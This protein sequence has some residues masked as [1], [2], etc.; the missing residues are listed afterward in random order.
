MNRSLRHSTG[1]AALALTAAFGLAA[2]SDD[3]D[4]SDTASD[5]TSSA[6]TSEAPMDDA[7]T[8][9][10]GAGCSSIPTDGAGSFS[11]MAS[12]PVAT[13]AS[14]NPLLKTLVTAVGA[15]NLVDT[16]NSSEGITVFAPTDDAFAQIPKAD[17]DA[18][19]A[20][21]DALTQVL[22]YHVVPGQ[23]PP[24]ELA[25]TH[26][27]LQGGDVTVEGSGEDFTVGEGDAAVLCGN[28]PTANATV[29][30][31]DSVLMP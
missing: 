17:L 11:G 14:A 27:T 9:P 19:L 2:C 25:G 3:S 26:T 29:Y 16:L 13:A 21:K 20:D 5:T 4:A 6:P 30:V 24:D 8:E 23:L 22:T 18:L 10:F 28:I 7:G 31:V 15:A 12:E 1:L